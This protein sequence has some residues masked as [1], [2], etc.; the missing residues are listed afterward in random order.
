[1][2]SFLLTH[3]A[4]PYSCALLGT[5]PAEMNL[6]H[7]TFCIIRIL[8]LSSLPI[9]AGDWPCYL[10]PTQDGK[11]D[12]TG[13]LLHWERSGPPVLWQQPLGEG[14]SPPVTARGLVIAFHRLGD[15][16]VI[17]AFA[18]DSG[19]S[20]WQHEY[21]TVYVDQYG[22]N[23]GPRSAPTIDGDFVYTFGAEGTLTCLNLADGVRTW[24]RH[25]NREF[26]V[27]QNFFGAGVPPVIEGNH[28]LL[29]V[30]S[31]NGAGV[32][33]FN[34][35]TG[36]MVW[37]MSDDEP[38]Y[39]TPVV[40]TLDG[41]RCAVFLTGTGL[42]ILDPAT[43]T[44]FHQYPF[45]SPKC[46]SVNAASPVIAGSTVFISASY[47]VG[48]AA[49]RVRQ[50]KLELVWRS[51]DAMQNHWATSLHHEGYIYGVDGR[52]AHDARLRCISL[53]DGKVQ[54]DGPEDMGRSTLIMA[55]GHVI[56]LGEGGHLVLIEATPERYVEKA[57]AR[58]ANYP[59]WAPPILS[60][61]RLF[62]RDERQLVCLD[63]RAAAE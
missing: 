42:L 57:R 20:I 9:L 38:S 47:G 16:E 54:W 24:Q 50:D 32:V 35:R 51:L 53:E 58:V 18:A 5:D 10:G 23:G 52:H 12:E 46:E 29:N 61:G 28:A 2:P 48:A 6:V 7:A 26:G 25:V 55:E 33:A 3:Q 30:G 34:K 39:S 14:Y 4:E 27:P 13:L 44:L 21:P 19:K 11:S 62:I 17:Q 1:M 63:L 8:L 37:Q 31:T 49:F 56:A 60:N 59:A 43:G 45:R 22:F 41:V 36:A 40:A 15:Q